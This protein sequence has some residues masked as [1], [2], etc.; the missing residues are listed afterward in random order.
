MKYLLGLAL[1]IFIVAPA[2]AQPAP[3]YQGGLNGPGSY[4]N[5]AQNQHRIYYGGNTYYPVRVPP[6]MIPS[7]SSYDLGVTGR[8]P[9]QWR[10]YRFHVMPQPQY[11]PL[12]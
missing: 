8:F 7:R 1:S 3:I 5:G 2:T 10:S 4:Y 11:Y 12:P 6:Q 9:P